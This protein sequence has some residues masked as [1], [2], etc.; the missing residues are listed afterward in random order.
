LAREE[1]AKP[2]GRKS[3]GRR[4][5]QAVEAQP[6]FGQ[7]KPREA[8]W[9]ACAQTTVSGK[10]V[11]NIEW[12]LQDSAEFKG[13]KRNAGAQKGHASFQNRPRRCAIRPNRSTARGNGVHRM[14][15]RRE[16][17]LLV[18]TIKAATID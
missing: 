7:I 6:F 3:D 15:L 12:R 9:F 4:C 16:R 5:V 11:T 18:P 1:W 13:T 14:T 10:N 8:V 2:R 17:D